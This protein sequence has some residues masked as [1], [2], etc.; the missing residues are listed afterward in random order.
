MFEFISVSSVDDA[1][2]PAVFSTFQR[3]QRL[4]A[5]ERHAERDLI[6][7]F[8]STPIETANTVCV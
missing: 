5:R 2:D 7:V 3:L 6:P 4:G 8:C 1:S